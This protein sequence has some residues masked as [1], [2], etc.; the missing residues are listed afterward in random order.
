M[1][2]PPDDVDVLVVG[3]GPTGL[4][5]ALALARRGVR[6]RIVDADDGP[7]RESRATDVHARTLELLDVLGVS[8]RLL[9]RGHTSSSVVFRSGGRE[10]A[11]VPFS[12]LPS[13]H[14]LVLGV[15]QDVTEGVLLEALAEA[16]VQ[17]RFATSVVGLDPV[18][19]GVRVTLREAN[20]DAS[21]LRVPWLV[22]ADGARSTVRQAL[23]LSF[24]GVTYPED[25]FVADVDVVSDVPRDRLH[26]FLSREGFLHVLPLPGV[27]RARLFADVPHEDGGA[28][29]TL[30]TLAALASRRADLPLR[31]ANMGWGARFRIHRRAVDRYRV[32]RALL[33]GDAAHVHSPV[34]GQGMNTGIQDA[35][36]LA[37]RLALV[38]NEGAPEA[39]LDAYAEER[40]AI[41]HLALRDTDS[42]TKIALLRA[43]LLARVR[44]AAASVAMSFG[45]FARHVAELTGELA[46][47]VPQ[48]PFV[49]DD[50]ASVLRADVGP[51]GVTERPTVADWVELSSAPSAGRRALDRDFGDGVRVHDLLDGRHVVLL[52][53]GAAATDEGYARLGGLARAVEARHGGR[54]RAFVVVPRTERP[55]TL[56]P[57]ASVLLDRQGLVHCGFGA[58][59]ECAYVLRPD[60]VIGYRAQ[61]ISDERLL[62]YLDSVF[63]SAA[64]SVIA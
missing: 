29:P 41:G 58:R 56:D 33:A 32:G 11:S 24:D 10:I 43:P 20:G 17:V 34:G 28:A 64:G 12:T 30:A 7:S 22:G 63:G 36:D 45:P 15:P 54:L 26:V 39:L 44:D 4:T 52:F 55:A 16:G 8:G 47:A 23:G 14:R 5:A 3:A 48:G 25:F 37:W 40:R 62:G 53:D 6:V 50:V 18:E 49:R 21:T 51:S 46:L 59:A 38:V 19:D 9:A 13:R 61:P 35:F 60:G 2:T 31:F 57:G 1:V 42:A 27:G